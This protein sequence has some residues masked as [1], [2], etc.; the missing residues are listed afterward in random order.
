[1]NGL[2]MDDIKK[3][4]QIEL[5]I[6]DLAYGG[7]G[8]ARKHNFVFFVNG[9]IPGQKINAQITKK[10]SNYAEARLLEVKQESQFAVSAKCCH[11]GS[12]GGCSLQNYQYEQQI[13]AKKDQVKDLLERIGKFSNFEIF[14]TL[15]SPDIFYYR[16]KMEFTFARKKWLS[17]E[18]MEE[19]KIYQDKPLYLGFHAKGLFSKVIDLVECHLVNPIAIDI[20]SFVRKLACDSNLQAYSTADHSGFWRFLIFRIGIQTDDIMVNIITSE[21][22]QK[23]AQKLLNIK[24]KFPQITSLINGTTTS[25][26]SVAFCEQEHLLDGKDYITDKIGEY[27]FKISANSFFQTNT[28]QV[29]ILYDAVLE[30]C[31]VQGNETIYDFYCGAGTI[32]IYLSKFVKRVVGFE[33]VSAAINNARENCQ[34]NGVKNCSFVLGDL[35]DAYKSTNDFIQNYGAPDVIILD[36]PRGGM[37]PKTIQAVMSLNPKRIVHVSCNPATLARELLEL[38]VEKYRLI[39][40]QPI[41]MFPHTAH[42]EAVAQ[43]T[44]V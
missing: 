4:K 20:L 7:R 8:I 38:C 6:E 34:I 18:E 40:V 29:K 31:D 41:D 2:L 14:P 10:K 15:P 43:L 33:S 16:N 22:D 44:R 3:G 28:K 39:K 17:R 30:Y 11:F 25:K 21:Y 32:S 27:T 5:N 13:L 12:C 42:I 36:P 19:V 37:H 26:S 9:A 23:I 1:M 35:K 24:Q